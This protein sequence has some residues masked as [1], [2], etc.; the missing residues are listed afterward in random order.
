MIVRCHSTEGDRPCFIL[1]GQ[2]PNIVNHAV[3][4][5]RQNAAREADKAALARGVSPEEL[6]AQK[7]AK[8][9]ERTRRIERTFQLANAAVPVAWLPYGLY[10]LSHRRPVHAAACFTGMAALMALGLAVGFRATWRYYTGAITLNAKRPKPRTAQP[11]SRRR[12]IERR[13]PF[14]D[15]DTAAMTIACLLIYIRQPNIYLMLLMPLVFGAL[16]L[17]Y[18][19]PGGAD[20]AVLHPSIPPM[21]AVIWPLFNF[22]FFLFNLF[23]IDATGFRTLVLLPTERRKFLLAKN[24]ALFPIVFSGSLLFIILATLVTRPGLEVVAIA[25]AHVLYL[26]IALA[27]VGNLMSILLPS[28]MAWQGLRQTAHKS[29]T[30]LAALLSI[31]LIALLIIPTAIYI[32]LAPPLPRAT[33]RHPLPLRL[34]ATLP[35]LAATSYLYYRTLP[36]AGN[37]L[38]RREHA[39]LHRLLR[40]RE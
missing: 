18:P 36:A 17:L 40:D 21:L 34:I 10:A 32:I 13:L 19:R 31:L 23:G 20:T 11:Q 3:F 33:A 22:S 37:L 39:I 28:R 1:L 4:L 35:L 27:A 16:F 12:L 5:P 26:Y 30:L 9:P 8:R 2:L 29:I 14:V 38:Q 15:D 6:S 24:L 25:L 7:K